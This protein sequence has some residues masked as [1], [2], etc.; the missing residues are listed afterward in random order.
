LPPGTLECRLGKARR[1]ADGDRGG[2]L[3]ATTALFGAL[4]VS[5]AVVLA[6]AGLALV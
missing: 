5:L 3:I 1:D 6:V 2:R 4:I